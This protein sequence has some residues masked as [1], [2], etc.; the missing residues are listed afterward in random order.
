MRVGFS[1]DFLVVDF[2]VVPSFRVPVF[3]RPPL[4]PTFVV[5][6]VVLV[7]FFAV[8]FCVVELFELLD[9]LVVA[10]FFFTTGFLVTVFLATGFLVAVLPSGFLAATFGLAGAGVGFGAVLAGLLGVVGTGA[11]MPLFRDP[12]YFGRGLPCFIGRVVLVPLPITFLTK[13]AWF[14]LGSLGKSLDFQMAYSGI[15]IPSCRHWAHLTFVDT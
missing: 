8:F 12:P 1:A 6:F 11:T 13:T 7:L 10:L 5:F 2:L 4:V 3:L 15:D 9:F 14:P